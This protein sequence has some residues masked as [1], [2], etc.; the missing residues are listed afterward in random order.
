MKQNTEYLYRCVATPSYQPRTTLA[1]DR[2][3]MH[4]L[5]VAQGMPYI[6]AIQAFQH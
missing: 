1:A 5:S 6:L 2:M 3:A 4:I